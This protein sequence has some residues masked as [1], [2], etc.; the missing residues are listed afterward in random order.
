MNMGVNGQSR[1][2]QLSLSLI[3]LT[4][5]MRIFASEAGAQ[6]QN[7]F[8]DAARPFGIGL[9]GPVMR[10]GSDSASAEFQANELPSLLNFVNAN[11]S[12]SQSLADISA[13]SL[14]P[15]ALTLN[16]DSTVRTYFLSEGA[17]YRNTLGY[18]PV[19]AQAGASGAQS[20]IFPDASSHNQYSSNPTDTSSDST[21]LQPGDF[22]D[23]GTYSA[24]TLIDFFLI[25]N[26]ANGGTNT[27]TADS[28]SN[29]DGMQ[30][31]VSYALPG[32]PYL[33]IGFEDLFGGGDM[34]YNDIVFAVDIGAANVERLVAVAAP[35][36]ATWAM[37]GLTLALAA[38]RF[39]R[40]ERPQV[41][42]G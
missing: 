31:V 22:V 18:T 21:P 1:V 29:P 39:R 9:A 32:S 4:A 7:Q 26:G 25:S 2:R 27:Y 10:A 36:P 23:L 16:L 30:H 34:D 8:Q 19:D 15:S 40:G 35:E 17:G 5:M 14:D 24:G 12:E 38:W 11:L 42:Q 13:V 20:L 6:T 28:A 37:M 41:S 3:A 33:I